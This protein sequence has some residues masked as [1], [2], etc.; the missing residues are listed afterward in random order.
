MCLTQMGIMLMQ[1]PV[2]GM[3]PIESSGACDLE[4]G[5]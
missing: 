4:G 2:E 1:L 3:V 5:G